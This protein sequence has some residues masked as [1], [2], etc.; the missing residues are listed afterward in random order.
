MSET[1]NVIQP[2]S[3]GFE[4]FK[5]K[6]IDYTSS[7]IGIIHVTIKISDFIE[8]LNIDR[9]NKV[10]AFTVFTTRLIDMRNETRIAFF[11]FNAEDY[12]EALSVNK[13]ETNL[14]KIRKG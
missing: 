7:E 8:A 5:K 1:T 2:G 9:V 4:Y 6:I 12:V 3:T 13:V 14:L 11:S 10:T